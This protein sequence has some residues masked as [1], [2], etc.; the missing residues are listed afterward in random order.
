M[1]HVVLKDEKGD[2]KDSE[3]LSRLLDANMMVIAMSAR[4][5]VGWSIHLKSLGNI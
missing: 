1:Y 2:M 4:L 5:Q 3:E